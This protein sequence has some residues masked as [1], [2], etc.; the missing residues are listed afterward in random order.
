MTILLKIATLSEIREFGLLE[1]IIC[2]YQFKC[3][4]VVIIKAFSYN[5]IFTMLKRIDLICA[6]FLE[7]C[8]TRPSYFGNYDA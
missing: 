8:I 2:Q 1:R 7:L 6:I 3:V 4:L 5:F